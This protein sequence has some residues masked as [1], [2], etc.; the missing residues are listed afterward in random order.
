[1]ASKGIAHREW[2]IHH[3]DYEDDASF[4]A[5]VEQEAVLNV[6]IMERLGIAIISAPIRRQVGESWFTEAIVFQTATVPGVRDDAPDPLAAVE[7]EAALV[8]DPA[9]V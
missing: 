7:P 9:G 4:R 8:E 3:S 5:A 1:M 2:A 6:Q